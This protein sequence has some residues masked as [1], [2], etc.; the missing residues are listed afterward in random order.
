MYQNTR[1]KPKGG[2]RNIDSKS[3]APKQSQ[4]VNPKQTATEYK[5]FN[6]N[7]VF[8]IEEAYRRLVDWVWP[9][10][11]Q[12]D[13][14]VLTANR[15]LGRNDKGFLIEEKAKELIGIHTTQGLQPMNT[16][17]S[18]ASA[19]R[20]I[21]VRLIADVCNQVSPSANTNVYISEADALAII[22][23]LNQVDRYKV[24]DIDHLKDLKNDIWNVLTDKTNTNNLFELYEASK[25]GEGYDSL[26]EK[27]LKGELK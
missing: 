12:G 19:L 1:F 26:I 23:I 10:G 8:A 2:S 6:T 16:L 3:H 15:L 27:A 22:N 20:G 25:T 4:P 5:V 13:T 17:V 7:P 11:K 9:I 14:T 18:L 24:F 21:Y